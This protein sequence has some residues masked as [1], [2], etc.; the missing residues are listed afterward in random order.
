MLFGFFRRRNDSGLWGEEVAA[1]MLAGIGFKV[2]GK[3]VRVGVRD[4][5]DILARDGDALVFVEVKTRASRMFGRPASSVNRHKRHVLSRAAA[6][7]LKS[8]KFPR[9]F[10]R[11]DV[12]EVVGRPG[13]DA[14]EVNHIRNAFQ[15]DPRYRLPY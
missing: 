8:R 13:D 5:I 12:V 9:V 10:F 14:P 6:R 4:E 7:Y 3:R 15:M 1:R 2:L 11:F